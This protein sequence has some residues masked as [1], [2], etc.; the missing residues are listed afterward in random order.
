MM[1]FRSAITS[2]WATTVPAAIRTPRRTEGTTNPPSGLERRRMR[3]DIHSPPSSG[4][5][6]DRCQRRRESTHYSRDQQK[7]SDP[8]DQVTADRSL[9]IHVM[10]VERQGLCGHPPTPLLLVGLEHICLMTRRSPTLP[11][12]C[13]APWP[14]CKST[15]SSPLPRP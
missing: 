15:C 10:E 12:T 3:C 11:L 6:E 13:S 8:A 14:R 4:P 5:Y 9:A 1:P 2:V 7:K